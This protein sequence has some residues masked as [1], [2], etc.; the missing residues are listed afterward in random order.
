MHVYRLGARERGVVAYDESL[1]ASFPDLVVLK[2]KPRQSGRED[3]ASP[4]GAFSAGVW[5]CTTGSFRITYPMDEIATLLK[6]KL[7]ITDERGRKTTLEAGDS[8][9][10]AKGETLTWDII[11]PVR[12]SYFLYMPPAKAAKAAAE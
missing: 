6:G 2:G 1:E 3:F 9:F 10:V 7:V 5:E 11:E 4:D 12:K 8:F